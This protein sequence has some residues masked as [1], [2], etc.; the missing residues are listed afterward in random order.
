V[1][2]RTALAIAMLAVLVAVATPGLEKRQSLGFPY[3]ENGLRIT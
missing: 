2:K 1:N 3:A